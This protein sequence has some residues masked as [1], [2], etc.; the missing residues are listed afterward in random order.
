LLKTV[1]YTATG[2]RQ[3]QQVLARHLL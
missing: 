2:Q 3:P 1:H